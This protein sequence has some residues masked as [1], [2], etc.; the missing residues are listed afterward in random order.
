MLNVQWRLLGDGRPE[1][2][3][4]VWNEGVGVPAD[5]CQGGATSQRHAPV[6]VCV[7]GLAINAFGL[8]GRLISATGGVER[9]VV[10]TKHCGIEGRTVPMIWLCI[11]VRL[12]RFCR[13]HGTVVMDGTLCDVRR[14]F[15]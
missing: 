15:N 14:L 11:V 7:R 5:N 8:C 6:A 13:A 3:F 1:Q 4:K 9:M 12:C 10:R 2:R